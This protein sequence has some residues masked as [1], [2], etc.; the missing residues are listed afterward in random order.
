MINL[1]P[2]HAI[3]IS[4]GMK[5]ALLVPG[6]GD[7]YAPREI[8]LVTVDGRI[9][10]YV[11][12]TRVE[13]G[14]IKHWTHEPNTLSSYAAASPHELVDRLRLFYPKHKFKSEQDHWTKL[15][16]TVIDDWQKEEPEKMAR[17]LFALKFKSGVGKKL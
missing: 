10:A 2:D 14:S 7:M 3:G 13:T 1:H 17:A 6:N 12:I 5:R 9:E 4:D 15:S 8:H 11:L 16:F